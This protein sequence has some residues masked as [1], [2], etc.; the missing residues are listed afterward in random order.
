MSSGS[1]EAKLS[2]RSPRTLFIVIILKS[3]LWIKVSIICL[4]LKI[5]ALAMSLWSEGND[6]VVAEMSVITGQP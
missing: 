1:L 2:V 3:M 4:H 6:Y 5:E